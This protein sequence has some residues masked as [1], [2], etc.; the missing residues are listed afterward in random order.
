MLLLCLIAT[1]PGSIAS[2][3]D[4]KVSSPLQALNARRQFNLSKAAND[5]GEEEEAIAA[6][7][8]A[9]ELDPNNGNFHSWKATLY[10]S[11]KNDLQT[12]LAEC[13]RAC[14][15]APTSPMLKQKADVLFAMKKYSEALEITNKA[16]NT[17]PVYIDAY[18]TKAI[19][20]MQLGRLAE[21]E[22]CLSAIAIDGS[23]DGRM[24]RAI[25][26][27]KLKHW[28]IVIDNTTYLLSPNVNNVP[29]KRLVDLRLMRATA[30]EGMKNFK[31]AKQEYENTV[32]AWP[33]NRQAHLAAQH[34][35]ERLGDTVQAN[36]QKQELKTIDADY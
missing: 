27:S 4:Q 34:F 32:A 17:K 33:D 6:A 28:K 8:Q 12:A 14:E 11:Y 35:Y 36:L 22:Q 7:N 19:I 21:A 24:L 3:T 26:A 23:S 13:N 15:I 30:Y 1:F 25:V 16:L 10:M 29:I 2:A 31:K 20:L 5:R 18:R 9:V